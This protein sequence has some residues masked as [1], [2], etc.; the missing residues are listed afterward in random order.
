L[1]DPHT[2]AAPGFPYAAPSRQAE[3]SWVWGFSLTQKRPVRVPASRV[4]SPFRAVAPGDFFDAPIISGYSTHATIEAAIYGALME[5]I[6]RDAFMIAWANQ[7]RLPRLAIDR[8]TDGEVGDY[9]AA[10]AE[11][12]IEVRCV[13]AD[14]DLGAHTVIA[15]ARSNRIGEPWSVVSAAAD[16]DVPAACRKALKELSANRL[17]VQNEM[18]AA[19][20]ALP[21]P[22]PQV[23]ID[24]RAHGLLHARPDMGAFLD[25]W[26]NSDNCVRLP[27]TSLKSGITS[28]LKNCIK[29]LMRAGLEVA[30]VDLTAPAMESLGLRTVKVLVPGTYPMNFDGRF[31]HFGGRRMSEA[32]VTAGLRDTPIDFEDL[33]TI[34]HPFP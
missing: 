7:L 16:L 24:E 22:D 20:N 1:F 8:S 23:V 21:P 30:M 25:I 2:R 6:E 10:F 12:G 9:L 19:G 14:L 33:C 29:V 13:L 32:P 26:W 5:V 3:L 11:R 15:I 4:F 17:N 34:P 28:R 27:R 31:P 18:R